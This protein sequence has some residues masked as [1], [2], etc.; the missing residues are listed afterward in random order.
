MHTVQANR[1]LCGWRQLTLLVGVRLALV[2]P[3]LVVCVASVVA[4][5]ALWYTATHLTFTMSRNALVSSQTRPVQA[6]RTIKNAFT[7]VDYLTVVI[8][9]QR[10][11]RGKQFVDALVTRL[12]ADTQHFIQVVAQVDTTRLEGK[13]LLYVS[14][15]DL[16]TL[17]QRLEDA[18]E[19]L[20]DL[21]ASPGLGTLFTLI[22]QEISKA[23]VSHLT[24]SLLETQTTVDAPSAGESLD[25][26][27]LTALF[28]EIDLALA[29]PQTYVF[30]SPWGRFFLKDSKVWAQDEYLT[31]ADERF[32]FVLVEP[33][34]TSGTL[35]KYATALRVLRGHMQEVLRDFPDV[36]AGVTGELALATD[37]M[38]AS[39]RD[40]TIASL[41]ALAGVALLFI[42][43]FRQLWHPLLVVITL[44]MA[45]C[46][47][48]GLTTLSVGHLNILSI[49]FAPMLIGLGIDFGIH[50]LAR[51]HE[52]RAH[53]HDVVTALVIT[54]RQTGPSVIAAALT[55]ALAFFVLLLVDFPGL[56]EL[57]WIA[58]SG[59]L[60]CLLSSFT[61][62][63]ALLTLYD[64][65]HQVSR[66]VWAVSRHDPVRPLTRLPRT[67]LSLIGLLTAAGVV[68]LP[69]PRFDYNLLN[70]QAHGTESVVWEYRLLSDAKRS[71]WYALSVADSLDDLY[72]KK[73]AFAALPEVERVES[74]ASL[75]PA[76]H[77]TRL[78]LIAELPSY[79]AQLNG[80]WD[81]PAPLDL[82]ELDELLAKLRFKLQREPASWKPTK[83]PAPSDLAAAR[84][85]LLSVQ[86]RLQ[87]MTPET[88]RPVL[89][90]FQQALMADIAS[91][92]S[93]LRDN[94][95]PTPITLQ[96][97]PAYLL[98]R[99]VGQDGRYLIHLSARQNI[100]ERES[101]EA[102]V[103]QLQ[104]VDAD[105]TGPPVIAWHAMRQMQQGYARGG[106]Y[107]LG[108]ILSIALV[109]FRR[110][111]PALFALLPLLV[112][113]MWTAA[114]MAIVQV[115]F[116]LANLMVLPVYMGIAI[117]SGIHLVHRALEHPETAGAPLT[118]S[119]GKAVLLSALTTVVGFG[120][121]M[122]AKH[123]GIFSL[124]Q[125]FTLAVGA[126]LVAAFVVLPIVVHLFPI[127]FQPHT[128]ETLWYGS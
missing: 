99:Y 67:T 36:Q 21:T 40:T 9:P 117:D 80:S 77:T 33:R 104:L 37:E 103:T 115:P 69:V 12:Q 58:G 82:T 66:G 128:R 94:L 41:L 106:L 57:G 18:E 114:G 42:I 105:I 112:G 45:I 59:I 79:V 53:E 109:L 35:L 3:R 50:M 6:W 73:A 76:D 108:V 10:V 60:L 123:Y 102:F 91:K 51:Y 72:R 61:V 15:D 121:L 127:R 22:N 122:I 34:P 7:T 111:K 23:L 64:R 85:A 110:L 30:A 52:E 87:V 44:V 75:M 1:R 25:V 16:R 4:V 93:L 28:T 31:A 24:A 48:L 17:R 113:A 32:F 49:A 107:A 65:R 90:H 126:N 98:Q 89:E 119:T 68:L 70:L 55:T 62:L 97:I 124:G 43:T 71:A 63:P 92:L 96:D 20:T 38:L 11:H 74:L 95:Y 39:Q 78:T 5:G 13:K 120:S 26:S 19:L 56:A 84:A 101:M 47:S 46:W 27:F 83:R 118:R 125:L 2:A 54:Y 14:A 29:D 116:N 81:Q 86:E 8:E 88:T 100:W